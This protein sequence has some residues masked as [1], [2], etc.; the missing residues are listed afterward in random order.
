MDAQSRAPSRVAPTSLLARAA[1]ALLV[2]LFAL[3]N[4]HSAHA[5]G[6]VTLKSNQVDEADGRWRLNMTINYGSTP[7]L[8]HIPMIFEFEMI[9]L[10]E[11][12]LTDQ[13]GDKPVLIRKP[14]SSQTPI[15]ESMDVGFSDPA[16]K[17]FSTTKFDFVLRRD[18]GFE[19]GEYNMKIKRVDDGA[20]MGQPQKITL[21]GDNPIVDRRAIVFSGE[22]KKKSADG[23]GDKAAGDKADKADKKDE[24]KGDGDKPAGDA[25]GVAPDEAAPEAAAPPPVAPKQGGC[26]CRVEER[27][28]GWAPALAFAAAMLGAAARRRRRLPA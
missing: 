19:A 13:S 23:D 3:L 14:L 21:K 28:G 22:K 17:V 20:I 7:H 9:T 25:S 11:R 24:P 16:G 8:P 12:A 1:L 5:V 27:D 10:Y 26:G 4:A 2:G 6:T 15:N 18:R